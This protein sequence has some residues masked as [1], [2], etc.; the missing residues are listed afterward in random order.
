MTGVCDLHTQQPESINR[1]FGQP[2]IVR[3]RRTPETMPDV[4]IKDRD[5][6]VSTF[7]VGS[8]G[9][10]RNALGQFDLFP[11]QELNCRACEIRI[12]SKKR[13]PV[14]DNASRSSPFRQHAQ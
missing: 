1:L 5:K 10:V 6:D 8:H 11:G 7:I 3:M 14:F 12:A 9:Y 13:T 2:V 4:P